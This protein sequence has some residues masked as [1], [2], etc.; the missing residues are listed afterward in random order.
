MKDGFTFTGMDKLKESHNNCD[1]RR[2]VMSKS[3]VV[4]KM[5]T[6]HADRGPMMWTNADRGLIRRVLNSSNNFYYSLEYY[7]REL[8]IKP[9]ICELTVR[10]GRRV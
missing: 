3:W 6:V 1:I 10:V 9:T 5:R 2:Y 8:D 7:V 4:P